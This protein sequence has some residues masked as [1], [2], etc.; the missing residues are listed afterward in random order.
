MR[1]LQPRTSWRNTQA[2][3]GADVV[4]G[5]DLD[6][7]ARLVRR[8]R[9]AHGSGAGKDRPGQD[10]DQEEGLDHIRET[11]FEGR[12]DD[13]PLTVVTDVEGLELD[14]AIRHVSKVAQ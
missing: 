3:S 11:L 2:R 12:H 5:S 1:P 13:S 4:E 6:R 14:L 9:A 10:G 7:G 8:R